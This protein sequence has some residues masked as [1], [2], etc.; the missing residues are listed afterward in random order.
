VPN[1]KF[2]GGGKKR[3]IDEMEPLAPPPLSPEE[4]EATKCFAS[5]T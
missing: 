5:K 1:P 3:K 2:K 4:L